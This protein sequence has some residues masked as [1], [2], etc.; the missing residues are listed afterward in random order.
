MEAGVAIQ[1]KIQY[2]CFCNVT[3]GF[4]RCQSLRRLLRNKREAGRVPC[5]QGKADLPRSF[6]RSQVAEAGA[7]PSP[8][9]LAPV[10]VRVRVQV[11]VQVR[12]RESAGVA[13]G[14]VQV[15]VQDFLCASA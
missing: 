13:A 1:Y 6:A 3:P 9:W 2:V 14:Q 11:R 4:R 15:Q 10:W 5:S 12:V 7:S 8:T